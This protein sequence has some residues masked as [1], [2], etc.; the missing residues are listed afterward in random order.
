MGLGLRLGPRRG[1]GL[2]ARA[3]P[4]AGSGPELERGR[5]LGLILFMPVQMLLAFVVFLLGS[6]NRSIGWLTV[7]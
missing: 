4:R 2:G 6:T 5:G 3:A 1:L 7:G